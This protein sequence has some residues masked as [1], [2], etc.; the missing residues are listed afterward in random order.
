MEPVAI[1]ER[2]RTETAELPALGNHVRLISEAQV[3]GDAGPV[4]RHSSARV[5]QHRLKARKPAVKLRSYTDPFA[6]LS[7]EVLA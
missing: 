1:R 3:E 5:R 4:H 7:R 6:E 2:L